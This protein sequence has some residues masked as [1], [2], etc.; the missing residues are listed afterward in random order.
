MLSD[1]KTYKGFQYF[2][3]EDGVWTVLDRYGSELVV[4]LDDSKTHGN[5]RMVEAANSEQACKDYIDWVTE[6]IEEALGEEVDVHFSKKR[7]NGSEFCN[8]PDNPEK[9]EFEAEKNE[10]GTE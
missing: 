4:G 3:G 7:W 9:P 5:R 2:C 6:L 8:L 1:P 10:G